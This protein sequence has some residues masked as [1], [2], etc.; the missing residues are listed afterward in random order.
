MNDFNISIIGKMDDNLCVLN[1]TFKWDYESPSFNVCLFENNN[2]ILKD[3][4]ST[5]IFKV[6]KLLKP[7]SEYS[8]IVEDISNKTKSNI[9]FKT[10][11]DYENNIKDI[12]LFH[13][14]GNNMIMQR[15]TINHVSGYG[16][17]NELI[18]LTINNES[19]YSISNETGF[20]EITIPPK[21]ETFIST[22]ICVSNGIDKHT[23]ISN[24]LFGDVYLF[25]GQSNMQWTTLDS[26]YEKDDIEKLKKSNIRFFAQDVTT[27][28]VKLDYCTNGRWFI[29]DDYN[30]M[31]FSAIATMTGAFL[32]DEL[33]NDTPIGIITACQ[34]DTNIVNWMGEDFYDGII[35]T[36]HLHYNAMVYPLRYASLN[37]VVWYQGCNNSS[38]GISY[39]DLLLNF[40]KNYR[41]LFNKKDLIFF[42]IGLACFD[43]DDG[44]N[45]DFS[46][47]RESQAL[48]CKEDKYSYF[49]STCDNGDP[50]YI[51]PKRKRYISE[52]V[53]KSIEATYYQRDYLK[54]G[55]SYKK[56]IVDKNR[57]IV[58]LN[59]SKGLYSIGDINNT[60]LAG[61]GGKYHSAKTVIEN[62]RLIISSDK[63]Q[64]P[65]YIKYGFKK[66][67]FVNIFN[68]DGYAITPFRTDKYGINIDQFEYDDTSSYYFHKDGSKMTIKIN[69]DNLDI[70]KENDGKTFGSIRLDKWGAIVYNPSG[71]EF[72]VKGTCSNAQISFRMIEGETF[73][74][75]GYSIKDD[76]NCEKTFNFN[77]KDLTLINGN[78]L[79]KF[80]PQ[81]IIYVEIMVETS[82]SASF[83]LCG[84]R[85]I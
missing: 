11:P 81:K 40:F 27:S 37:G 6:N 39:K 49:I 33:K 57:V 46:Y 50:T 83:S 36:K 8:L 32:G 77:I 58:E 72:K 24:V 34:G 35:S 54:E 30:C 31:Y 79:N 13:P 21:K 44:N 71:F 16:P 70:Y 55:P 60:Y 28:K 48:A 73:D 59:S 75:W 66:S 17:I 26:D 5:N 3:I 62:D 29:P 80:D 47:V 69:G 78:P 52:R 19:Y 63:V 18:T 12:T 84:A 23:T 56:H 7:N 41:K 74:I 51:H 2:I 22:T 15:N 43:G 67:P 38:Q 4:T 1:P 61:L 76:F 25:A 20:F 64:N 42:V 10:I 68:K 14:F 9:T 85:F 82:Q 65:V 45:F 53:A